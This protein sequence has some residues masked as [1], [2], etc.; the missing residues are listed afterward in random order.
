MLHA[1]DAI[2]IY[3]VVINMTFFLFLD[4]MHIYPFRGYTECKIF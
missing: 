1:C 2:F 4:R 3:S